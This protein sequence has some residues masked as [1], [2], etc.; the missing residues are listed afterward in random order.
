MKA[1][2]KVVI[3]LMLLVVGYSVKANV[4]PNVNGLWHDVKANDN[5][6]KGTLI[7]AQDG[8]RIIVTHYLEFK[9]VPMVEYGH[10]SREGNTITYDVI[11]TQPIPGWVTKGRHVLVLSD[12]GKRLVGQ[13][14]STEGSGPL[15]FIKQ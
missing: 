3:A 2:L 1:F 5:F 10:G 4:T 9:G 12:D 15:A 6:A 11:V 8:Q 7:I 13:Y 14:H